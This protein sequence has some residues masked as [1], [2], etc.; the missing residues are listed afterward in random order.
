MSETG[1]LRDNLLIAAGD[2]YDNGTDERLDTLLDAAHAYGLA[3]GREGFHR[4]G[5]SKSVWAAVQERERAIWEALAPAS[6]DDLL[7]HVFERDF[8]TFCAAAGRHGFVVKLEEEETEPE[9]LPHPLTPG[10]LRASIDATGRAVDD[11]D[12]RVS[13]LEA[14][15]PVTRLEFNLLE[16]G[17]VAAIARSVSDHDGR[18]AAL[19][20]KVATLDNLVNGPQRP[21][22]YALVERV[23]S[24]EESREGH[25]LAL[26]RLN[27]IAGEPAWTKADLDGLLARVV[28]LE[29]RAEAVDR[30][31]PPGSSQE[32]SVAGDRISG[33]LE[34]E[35]DRL[36]Q[37]VNIFKY[38]AE[39]WERVVKR[40]VNEVPEVLRELV[41]SPLAL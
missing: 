38:R 10:A 17:G 1:T 35:N 2:F 23:R 33:W 36:Q 39:H 20:D 41:G 12:R 29:V 34:Q 9:A 32:V 15:D 18:I 37:Q 14:C 5:V 28:K 22:R 31:D 13:R 40:M 11:C 6:K 19:T 24:L 8:R 26:S 25:V 21:E 30:I 27:R 3:A 7:D 4:L 16:T